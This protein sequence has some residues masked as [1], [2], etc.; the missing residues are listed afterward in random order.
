MKMPKNIGPIH[1]VGIGGI[2]MSGIAEI[3]SDLGYSVQ[4][5]DLKENANVARLRKKGV[6][7]FVG[8]D[9]SNLG[10]AVLVIVSSAVKLDNPEL[11]SASARHIPIIKRAAMLAELMRFKN[12]IAVS[13]THGKTTTTSMAAT[14][15]DGGGFDPTVVNGGIINSYGTNARLGSGEWIVVEA[16]ESDGSFI[17]LP[18]GIAI[19]TN[20]NREHLDHYGHF[21]N[22]R[23]AFRVFLENIPFYGLAVLC[24]DDPEVRYL[25][26]TIKNCRVLTY[27]EAPDSDVRL[28]NVRPD[29]T[30]TCFDLIFHNHSGNKKE[31]FH[32]LRL[33]M[34]GRHNTLNAVAAVIVA[35]DLGVKPDE[36]QSALAGFQGV[37]RRFTFT[38]S[39]RGISVFDDYAHHPAEISVVLKTAR[40][41]CPGRVIAVFQPHRYTRLSYLFDEFCTCFKDADIVIIADIFASGEMPI[42][43]IN[44]DVLVDR[45]QAIGH[46]HVIALER[47]EHL[48]RLIASLCRAED[49][50]VCLGAGDITQWACALPSDLD[51]LAEEGLEI[52]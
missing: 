2:G 3:L 43:G 41:I 28:L 9:S 44:R 46:P 8:H 5:S 19:V 20:I 15:L 32:D 4:G 40:E 29:E 51:K 13:G 49:F 6:L 16:D 45:I 33:S 34:P 38:G 10:E 1:F 47:R 30:G 26:A 50:V 39:S 35:R 25:S 14:L 18:V 11:I 27:G 48:H 21:D 7:V 12:S 52:Q 23:S 37:K 24:L 36:I 42:E 17:K 22:L 31:V